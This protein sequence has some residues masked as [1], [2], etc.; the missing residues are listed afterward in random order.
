MRPMANAASLTVFVWRYERPGRRSPAS[1]PPLAGDELVWPTEEDLRGQVP[2]KFAAEGTLD[3][4]RL[5]RE[6]LPPRG[7]VAAAPLAGDHE[8]PPLDGW[9]SECHF[10]SIGEEEANISTARLDIHA[11]FRRLL[12]FRT[13]G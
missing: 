6:F 3:R 5:E 8:K 7:H 10:L 1:G 2:A 9:E 4:D 12:E 11:R 13:D